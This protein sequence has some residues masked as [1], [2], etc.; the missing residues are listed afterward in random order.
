M[1]YIKQLAIILSISL[2]AELL[3]YV[4]PLPIAASV[5]GLVLMLLGLITGL[6][7][8]KAVEETADFLVEAMPIMFIPVTVSIMTN[9]DVLKEL[10]LPL[11]VISLA[12]TVLIMAVT[13]RV[14]QRIIRKDQL[15]GG[16]SAAESRHTAVS[17]G[18]KKAKEEG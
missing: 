17:G 5:Y 6:I 18:S 14:A 8:L 16:S 11:T 10:L 4:I 1:K 7:P 12:T 9:I 3:E 15:S 13:G 2:V